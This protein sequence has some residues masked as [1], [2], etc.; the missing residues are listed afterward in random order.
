MDPDVKISP[1]DTV[2]SYYQRTNTIN[3]YIISSI[4]LLK[5]SM[6]TKGIKI[7]RVQFG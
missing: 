1:D 6:I 4:Q 5:K 2:M 3:T 7:I